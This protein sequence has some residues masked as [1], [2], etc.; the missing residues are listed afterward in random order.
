MTRQHASVICAFVLKE[1][2]YMVGVFNNFTEEND[3]STPI[4]YKDHLKQNLFMLKNSEL[5][6]EPDLP[7]ESRQLKVYL[8]VAIVNG[9][10]KHAIV[11]RLRTEKHVRDLNDTPDQSNN[12]ED[13]IQQSLTSFIICVEAIVD[14]GE[15][16][17]LKLLP[18]KGT[19]LLGGMVARALLEVHLKSDILETIDHD[20]I[21]VA[22]NGNPHLRSM[23]DPLRYANAISNAFANPYLGPRSS[24]KTNGSTRNM[25]PSHEVQDIVRALFLRD[26]IDIRASGFGWGDWCIWLGLPLSLDPLLFSHHKNYPISDSGE[27]WMMDE[28][29]SH[30]ISTISTFLHDIDNAILMCHKGRSISRFQRPCGSL[31]VHSHGVVERVE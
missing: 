5:E 4:C 13:S 20:P 30:H 12:Q 23:I 16:I 21:Y 24:R 1:I 26:L 11:N 19:C 9:L 3:N 22:Q 28:V 7:P 6:E 14:I 10:K 31:R 17:M 25:R 27:V 15:R 8:I 18:N 2:E 29:S